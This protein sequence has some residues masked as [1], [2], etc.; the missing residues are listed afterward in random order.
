MAKTMKS[1]RQSLLD[2]NTGSGD[3]IFRDVFDGNLFRNF[4]MDHLGLFKD[5]HDIA[6]HLSLDG[7][8]LVKRGHFEASISNCLTRPIC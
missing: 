8:Q 2:S 4:H 6:F 5:P 7:V 1:Y 3:R